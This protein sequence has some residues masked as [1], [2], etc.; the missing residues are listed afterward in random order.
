MADEIIAITMKYSPVPI[1]NVVAE[2]PELPQGETTENPMPAPNDKSTS[3]RARDATAPAKTAAQD[4]PGTDGSTKSTCAF[5]LKLCSIRSSQPPKWLPRKCSDGTKVPGGNFQREGDQFESHLSGGRNRAPLSIIPY[6][7][8]ERGSNDARL[9][10]AA[11]PR[12]EAT[13]AGLD[14]RHAAPSGSRRDQ[15][16]GL[17][18]ADRDEGGH[19]WR[20]RGHRASSP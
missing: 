15:L 13:D 14:R 18:Q 5:C 19:Y 4:T 20:R 16:Q 12:P 2:T 1:L 10:Q 17:G 8:S 6:R 9:S 7:Q 11:L 3:V